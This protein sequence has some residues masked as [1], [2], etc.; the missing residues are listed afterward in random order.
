MKTLEVTVDEFVALQR[1]CLVSMS[2][3]GILR[4]ERIYAASIRNVPIRVVEEERPR[5]TVDDLLDLVAR[6]EAEALV[7]QGRRAR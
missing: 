3:E 6:Y 2:L 5:R 7:E 4:G 1:A